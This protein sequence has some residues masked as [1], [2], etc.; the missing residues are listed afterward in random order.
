M[1]RWGDKPG[2]VRF[3]VR[4]L[5]VLAGF[6]IVISALTE[7]CVLLGYSFWGF[8]LLRCA[9]GHRGRC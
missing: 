3:Y 6:A 9:A 1:E 7:Y 2:F 8:A 5:L 4:R